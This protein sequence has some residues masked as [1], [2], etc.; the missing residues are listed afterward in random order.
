MKAEMTDAELLELFALLQ[1]RLD[2]AHNVIKK[3]PE[4]R[5]KQEK[6]E[7]FVF[8]ANLLKKKKKTLKEVQR[9]RDP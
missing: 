4:M 9:T 3:E 7:G 8:A 5:I 2:T 1:P 6:E